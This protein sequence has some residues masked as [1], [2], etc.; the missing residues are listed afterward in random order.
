M[1]EKY[2]VFSNEYNLNLDMRRVSTAL[3][4]IPIVTS[5]GIDELPN[6]LPM[7]EMYGVS[8]LNN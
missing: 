3:A 2:Q 7:L 6:V 8:K 4:N 5:G 1:N